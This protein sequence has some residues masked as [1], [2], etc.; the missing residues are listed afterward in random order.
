MSRHVCKFQSRRLIAFTFVESKVKYGVSAFASL[1]CVYH[2]LSEIL[3]MIFKLLTSHMF[4]ISLILSF[5]Y[6]RYYL[7]SSNSSSYAGHKIPVI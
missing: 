1:A 6:F 2:S 4:L 3:K 5:L 7:I